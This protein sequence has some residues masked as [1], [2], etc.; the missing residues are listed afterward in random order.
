M[1]TVGGKIRQIGRALFA[2]GETGQLVQDRSGAL[3]TGDITSRVD[4]WLRAGQVWEAHFATSTGTATIENN[5]ALD[6]A[7]PFFRFGVKAGKVIVPIKVKIAAAVIWETSDEVMVAVADTDAAA[8][9]GAVPTILNLAVGTASTAIG[10]GDNGVNTPLDGDSP[11][12]EGTVTNL[13]VLDLHTH[14]TGEL[15]KPY[16]YNILKGDTVAYIEGL[17]TFLVYAARTTTTVEVHYSVTWAALD[18][19]ELRAAA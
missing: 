17:G 12:T 7:E 3:L 1:T 15:G 6:L 2:D 13:R 10:D 8:T 9:G 18:A 16:E 14:V 19:A 4:G 5:T 11:I